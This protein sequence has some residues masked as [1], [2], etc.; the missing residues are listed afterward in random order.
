MQ[1]QRKRQCQNS[2]Y[3]MHMQLVNTRFMKESLLL[4]NWLVCYCILS[5]CRQKMWYFIY[6]PV[7]QLYDAVAVSFWPHPFIFSPFFGAVYN[8]IKFNLFNGRYNL[9]DILC[10]VKT[11]IEILLHNLMIVLTYQFNYFHAYYVDVYTN[12]L[13]IKKTEGTYVKLNKPSFSF[14]RLFSGF[15]SWRLNV[16]KFEY[17]LSHQN[18]LTS[19]AFYPL[20]NVICVFVQ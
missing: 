2:S 13:Y 12:N 19:A 17:S 16:L 8:F 1:N 6:L 11:S 15:L 7:W 10:R 3:K 4:Y 14:E 5:E 18:N 9:F 20:L